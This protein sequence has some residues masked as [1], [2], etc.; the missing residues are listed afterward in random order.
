[1]KIKILLAFSIFFFLTGCNNPRVIK[2]GSKEFVE[3]KILAHI[4]AAVIEKEGIAVKKIIPFGNSFDCQEGIKNGDIDIYPEYTGTGLALMGL[5]VIRDKKLAFDRVKKLFKHFNLSWL[6]SFGIDNSY[7]LVIRLSKSANFNIKKI[8][9]LVKLKD[10][11]RIATLPEFLNRTVDGMNGLLRRYGLQND[12]DPI[13]CRNKK[14]LYKL[15][16]KDQVDVIIGYSTD[17]HLDEPGLVTLTD[18]LN[19][20]PPYEACPLIRQEIL[21]SFPSVKTA[22]LKLKN[23]LTDEQ[24]RSLN[25]K[26]EINGYSPETVAVDF[27][28]S[29][30]IL[31]KGKKKKKIRKKLYIAFP[32]ADLKMKSV[33]AHRLA[34]DTVRSAIP[35]RLVENR[36]YKNPINALFQGEAYLAVV[37]AEFFFQVR[38]NQFPNRIKEIE[39]VAVFGNRMVHLLGKKEKQ[40]KFP[41]LT[42]IG[43]GVEFG[44]SHRVA[45]FLLDA[46]F[47]E[48]KYPQ[49]IFGEINQQI[50]ALKND[51]L[52]AVLVMTE[53][54]NGLLTVTLKDRTLALYP[55]THWQDKDRE[56]RF[57]FLRSARIPGGSYPDLQNSIE[58]LSSQLV[59]AGCSPERDLLLGTGGPGSA[60]QVRRKPIPKAIKIR[61]VNAI[62][63]KEMIDPV[64]PGKNFVPSGRRKPGL[65]I[66]PKPDVSVISAIILAFLAFLFFNLLAEDQNS[67]FENKKV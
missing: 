7:V 2:V 56:Y 61:L 42:R 24:V 6:D 31:T 33:V 15:L 23:I 60:F 39:A 57:P 41:D 30:G 5:P 59:F 64:L 3:G 27:L 46:Y 65:P 12:T 53:P 47:T 54:G 28:I 36:G 43:V 34:L 49:L 1:M 16:L 29:K 50:Q 26:V 4:L 51:E 32:K 52:E 40:L 44:S 8:S 37:G 35:G 48:K 55:L 14:Q 21:K 22:L 66:N 18:D 38:K 11:M 19:F 63:Q 13:V 17:G 25:K 62:G 45:Q 20:F 67:R 10:G 58:T 9:D